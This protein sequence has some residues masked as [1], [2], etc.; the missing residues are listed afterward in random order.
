MSKS[1][2]IKV[3]IGFS[4]IG[5]VVVAIFALPY[6]RFGRLRLFGFL[7]GASSGSYQVVQEEEFPAAD[8]QDIEV[9]WGSGDASIV[10]GLGDTFVVREEARSNLGSKMPQQAWIRVESG[11][12]NVRWNEDGSTSTDSSGARGWLFGADEDRRITIEVPAAAL[13]KLGSVALSGTS[14][15]YRLGQLTCDALEANFTSGVLDCTGTTAEQASFSYTSGDVV[16]EEFET[17]TLDVN[18]TSGNAA[19]AGI[20]RDAARI[21]LTSGDVEASFTSLP[22]TLDVAFTTGDV[23]LNLPASAGFTAR[24]AT[25]SGDVASDFATS[26]AGDDPATRVYRNGD[27]SAAITVTFTSGDL[28]LR[29]A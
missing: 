5:L 27:G 22:A 9:V 15:S 7:E 19:L 18:L 17:G 21:E 24:V 13:D 4:L 6:L 11:C 3:I 26:D 20:V 8:I 1:D 10:P 2:R 12:L 14:G 28:I 23:A 16:T 25:M 29:R